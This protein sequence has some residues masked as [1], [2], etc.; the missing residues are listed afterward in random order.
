MQAV[1][2]HLFN[3][4][5]YVS[6]TLWQLLSVLGYVIPRRLFMRSVQA[7]CWSSLWL[8]RVIC[9]T[10][11]EFRGRENIPAGGCLVA[12][13]HQSVWETFALVA[14]FDDPSFILKR[15]LM[16]V[17]FFGWMAAKMRL[18]AI[19]RGGGAAALVGM[20]RAAREEVAAGRQIVI[21]P[22]GTRRPAGAEPAYKFGVAHLYETLNAPCLPVALNSGLY[23]PRRSIL[24]RRGTI[25][26][27]YLEPIPPGLSRTRFFRLL[28]D[29]IET[30]SRRLH[31]DGMR[32][33]R[34]LG[35]LPPAPEPAE[36]ATSPSG[37][38]E[39]P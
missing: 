29:R 18:I 12:S 8:L 21:F 33:L 34:A 14:Q 6:F 7:W 17:P 35:E 2:S 24:R 36:A 15:E 1:R 39:Q 32:E 4:A 23:W 28:Q 27:E 37:A 22:E 30:A 11:V 9:G 10:R 3:L 16:W 13:K 5:F 38:A 20:T 19:D 26:V 31:E 25:V